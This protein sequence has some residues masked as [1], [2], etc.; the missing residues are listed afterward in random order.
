VREAL[1]FAVITLGSAGDLHPFLAI[2][3]ALKER[4]HRVCLM[5]QEPHRA[6]VE[7][8]GVAFHAIAAEEAH[9]RT[10]TH[11]LLWHPLDG[12]G[13]LW[14]HL[15]VPAIGLTLDA[16]SGWLD[17]HEGPL[18]LFASPLAA[19]ARLAKAKWPDRIRLVSG[20]TAPM[21]LRS[22]DDPMVLGAWQV[23]VWMPRSVRRGLWSALDRWKLEPMARPALQRWADKL[24]VELGPASLFGQWLHGPD[25]G[26]ALYP[27]WFAQVPQ[28][29]RDKGV[30]QTGFPLYEPDAADAHDG[31][32]ARF[33]ADP[34]PFVV[35]FP[36]SA[37][38]MAEEFTQRVL[39]ACRSLQLRAMVLSGAID[40]LQHN[41][42]ASTEALW[43]PR[44]SLAQCLPKAAVFVHHGGIGSL[45]QGVAA[46]TPQLVLGSAYDQFENG[47]RLQ[48]LGLGR[49]LRMANATPQSIA[50]ALKELV[51]QRSIPHPP[52][53]RVSRAGAPNAAVEVTCDR[54]EQWAQLDGPLASHAH[55]A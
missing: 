16:I 2:A 46:G 54:L 30:D 11:P 53:M 10:L 52:P 40:T 7:A 27:E 3:R 19:G 34:R 35:L 6:A 45:A 36:G 42:P 33:L 23:P 29:W 24:G 15:A 49:Q 22:V 32:V 21:G 5:S 17:E 26:V 39:P 28:S 51:G 31:S 8:D 9:T 20:Y 50:R 1:D 43:V 47:V 18:L 37:S 48:A 25:G 13:V 41:G 44:V 14:R 55:A 38:T 12:F 4:G